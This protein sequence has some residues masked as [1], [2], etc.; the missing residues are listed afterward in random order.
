VLGEGISSVLRPAAQGD[1][2][3]AAAGLKR[4]DPAAEKAIRSA[5]VTGSSRDL[6]QDAVCGVRQLADVAVNAISPAII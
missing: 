2:S 3:D 5:V 6:D 1:Q 4:A